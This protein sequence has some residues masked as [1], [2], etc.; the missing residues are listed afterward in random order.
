MQVKSEPMA[1][2]STQED[3]PSS[4]IN[5]NEYI[6]QGDL[7]PLPSL[8]GGQG[9]SPQFMFSPGIQL[10]VPLSNPP[11]RFL[12]N[13]DE[14]YHSFPNPIMSSVILFD[15]LYLIRTYGLENYQA[16]PW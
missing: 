5:V 16:L 3:V 15:V 1:I 13:R 2:L 8:G 7:T 12:D 4:G 6:N 10:D 14:F 11:T 9:I